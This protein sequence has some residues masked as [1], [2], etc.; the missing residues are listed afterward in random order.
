MPGRTFH[1]IVLFITLFTLVTAGATFAS[2]VPEL[3]ESEA[4]SQIETVI[5]SRNNT[6]L[7]LIRKFVQKSPYPSVRSR[8]IG[9]LMILGDDNS[10]PL[11]LERLEK[12]TDP[13][14]RR[15]AAY[16]LSEMKSIL[17]IAPLI[18]AATQDPDPLVR[19]ACA[20][21]LGRQGNESGGKVLISLLLGDSSYEVRM[22]AAKGLG[23]LKLKEGIEALKIAASKDGEKLV[24]LAAVQALQKFNDRD[25]IPFFQ[26]AFEIATDQDVK[27]ELFRGLLALKGD[28][29]TIEIGLKDHDER[30]RFA[31][32][33]KLISTLR[34]SRRE[35]LSPDVLNLLDD[36]L[37]DEFKGIRDLAKD[38]LEKWGYRIKDLGVR[39]EI[40]E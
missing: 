26:K 27:V 8:A 14:V 33:E 1:K 25:L 40:V 13:R 4:L 38:T 37:S 35:K 39:Y 15:A 12:D 16:A 5:D 36:M 32:L 9:A 6:M 18:R 30:M 19:A 23:E 34:R 29:K 22:E 7:P 2:I 3:S 20:R 21:A 24:R 10:L 31:A 17:T 11:V 28:R